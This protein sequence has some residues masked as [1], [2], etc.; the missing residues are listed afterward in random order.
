[1]TASSP[2]DVGPSA[3]IRLTERLT[4]AMSKPIDTRILAD[5]INRIKA[6]DGPAALKANAVVETLD[7]T[8]V[9]VEA[10]ELHAAASAGPV[11]AWT[12][13]GRPFL[14]EG[15]TYLGKFRIVV[16]DTEGT[17][18][19]MTLRKTQL[20][21][22]FA[23]GQ[24]FEDKAALGVWVEEM[25][26]RDAK[27]WFRVSIR[28]LL[29]ATR[30]LILAALIGNMLAIGVSLF[31]LQVWDRVI[32]ANS[33][34]SLT[35]L[36]I[37][38]AIAILFELVL[39][40]QRAAL[41][42]EVGAQVDR[43]ISGW[44]FRHMLGLKS[45]ARPPSLGSLASQIREINQIREAFSSSMLSAAIDVPFVLVFIFVIYLI[46]NILVL[47]LIGAVV[48]VIAIGLI[49]QF[50][51]ARLAKAGLEEAALRNG[52]IVE[53]VLKGDEVKLQQAED[54]MQLRWNRAV[55]T[56]S[57]ISISQRRWRNFLTNSTQ[58]IQQVTYVLV[59]SIGAY[60]VIAGDATMGQVIA[61][62]ILA[63]RSIAPLTQVSNLLGA[64]QGSLVAK[65][66]IDELMTRATDIPNA[67][68]LRRQLAAPPFQL[69]NVRYDYPGTEKGAIIIPR[70]EIPFGAKIG[71]IGRIGSG[72]S[73][74]LRLLSG[75]A[76]PSQG[77]VLLD[78]T[79]VSSIHADDLRR[80]IGFQS[81]TASLLRGTV[82]DNLKIAR[83]AAT[84]DEMMRAC[85][86]S[87]ALS[88]IRN[89]PRGLDL[90]I[91]E[92]G[93]GLSGGQ[94]QSLLLARTILRDPPVAL[95]DEPT[96]SMDDESETRFIAEMREWS[97]EKTLIVATHKAR[98][99][100]LCDRLLVI[101]DGRIARDGAKDEVLAS[102]KAGGAEK[103]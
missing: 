65:R 58:S 8:G 21:A 81:Q 11:L 13:E 76:D 25:T 3:W 79:E 23:G 69:K 102:L 92:A 40:L 16:V 74:L 35:V 14:I 36:L 34:N 99:L 45:D 70:L 98:P 95:F 67:Q 62:S 53:A 42:D 46:G 68:H 31:A 63:N 86:I 82:R 47:P 5:R 9:F 37:G 84:D 55:E 26:P 54:T 28:P 77:T 83:P 59:V 94:K 56:A 17:L 93:E 101:N 33:L 49:A 20:K 19:E 32:P 27:Q 60:Y 2:Q 57:R 50:P 7:M 44:V 88:L 61:C 80:A 71:V 10:S 75:L 1:M 29:R 41:I 43:S 30:H 90:M 78:G 103:R 66:S 87:Q 100:A 73:T 85:E 4:N 38:V 48:L 97:A 91:N 22:M 24:I 12:K 72:K 64:L 89:N 6:E 51:L 96:A 39:R 15:R 18:R 52:L